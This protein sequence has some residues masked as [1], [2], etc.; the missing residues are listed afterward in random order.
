M[1]AP[2]RGSSAWAP[3]MSLVCGLD[4]CSDAEPE[5]VDLPA[6]RTGFQLG[7][8]SF[9]VPAG[10]E[11]QDC[12]YFRVPEATNVNRFEIAQAG[13]T[14]HM[15]M[16]RV[17]EPSS[18]DDGEVQRGCW[19]SLPF[20]DWGLIVNSQVSSGAR[21]G[22]VVE[23]QLPEGVAVR[24]TEGELIMIQTHYVNGETQETSSGLGEVVINFHGIP[25]REV[26]AEMGSMFANN[27][28]LYLKSGED[29]SYTSV[30]R[31]PDAIQLLALSGHFHSRGSEFTVAVADDQGRAGDV[32]YESTA[33]DDPPF[34]TLGESGVAIPAGGGLS[35]TCSFHN[36]ED[37]DIV[38]GP[39]V[40]FEE[41]CN[42]FAF[43]TPKL[44]DQGALYCF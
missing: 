43:Y 38:F 31:V 6:P 29:A 23:W 15:N 13:G 25:D 21:G 24:L 42:L 18:F 11:L 4:G 44:T 7:T 39:H 37:Y 22:G 33:W 12:Y 27:R 41:H 40:E 34:Q 5:R 3:I 26:T 36:G 10:S 35:Y 30:C 19:D 16:F 28:N 8:G 17:S 14:H 9:D 2:A 32:L 1:R 20:Q